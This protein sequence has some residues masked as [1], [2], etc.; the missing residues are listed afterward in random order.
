MVAS[1]V[2][3][4]VVAASTVAAMVVVMEEK[5]VASRSSMLPLVTRKRKLS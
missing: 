3:A 2:V 4:S 1:A 5:P